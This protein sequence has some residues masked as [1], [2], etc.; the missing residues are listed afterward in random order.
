MLQ[1]H[2]WEFKLIQISSQK[3]AISHQFKIAPIARPRPKPKP[4]P[5]HKHKHRFPELCMHMVMV[6]H[7]DIHGYNTCLVLFGFFLN[8]ML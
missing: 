4:K 1:K 8:I 5:K 7:M 2:V 6:M 3:T